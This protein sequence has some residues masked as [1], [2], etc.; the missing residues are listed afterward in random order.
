MQGILDDTNP[1]T[2]ISQIEELCLKKWENLSRI[3][4][5]G[6]SRVMAQKPGPQ[7]VL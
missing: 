6:N 7:F 5:K 3:L 1:Y 2:H 4:G